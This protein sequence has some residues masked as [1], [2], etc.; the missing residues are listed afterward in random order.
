MSSDEGL[1]Y[2]RIG[3][4]LGQC[5]WG[6]DGKEFCELISDFLPTKD[7][8]SMTKEHQDLLGG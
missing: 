7:D 5:V 3:Y 1:I 8:E 4:G 6:R 2:K